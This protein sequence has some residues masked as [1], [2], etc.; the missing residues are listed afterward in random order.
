M[1]AIMIAVPTITAPVVADEYAI[2]LGQDDVLNQTDTQSVAFVIEYHAS[3]FFSGNISDYSLVV[4]G[5]VDGDSDVWLGIGVYAL[6]SVRFS[7][8]FFE[9][10]FM[11][12]YYDR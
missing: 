8:W 2:G 7:N 10:S 11:P 1:A 6:W 5:Q 9:G 3:P 4:A 12:G